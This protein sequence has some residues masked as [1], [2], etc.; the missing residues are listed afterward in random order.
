MS[1]SA[2]NLLRQEVTD[3]LN[4]L[5]Q[6]DN[7]RHN[8]PG[9]LIVKALVAVHNRD[10]TQ[11]TGTHVTGHS[12]HIHHANDEEGVTENQRT[13]RLRNHHGEQDGQL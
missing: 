2:H 5:N 12:G 10:L 1:L 9:D 13:K 8:S 7:N 3:E 11:T 6:D 4:Q